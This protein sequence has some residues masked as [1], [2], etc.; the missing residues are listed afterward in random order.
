MRINAVQSKDYD[1]IRVEPLTGTIGAEISGVDLRELDDEL[2]SEL[3][4]AWMA[5][6]VLFF[7]DQ[8]LTQAQHVAYGRAFG[9]LEVHPF[10]RNVPEHPEILVL[11]STADSFQAAETWHSDVTFRE[12]PPLGSILMGR[13]IPAYGGDTCWAN[14]ELAYEQLPDDVKSQIEGRYAIHSFVKA[15]G[16]GMSENEREE[17]RQKYP[18]QKHPVVRTHPVTGAKSLYVNR[19]FTLTID[20]MTPDESRALR[21]RLYAQASEP[22]FQCRFRWRPSSIA[23]WDNRCTQHYAVPDHGGL[24]RRMERVT[25]LGDR[26]T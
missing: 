9:E 1:R 14:M 18:D 4:D 3:H 8:E 21:R 23:Q 10:A 20:G 5:H 24:H 7:R 26:P 16:R 13:V 15:F 19:T 25:L 12:C 6:K 2:I 17:A 22:E 11:E